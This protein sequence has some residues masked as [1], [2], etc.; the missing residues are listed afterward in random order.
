MLA[1][2][3]ATG[4]SAAALREIGNGHVRNKKWADAFV[5][6]SH[7]LGVA[8]QRPES[9][10]EGLEAAKAATNRAFVNLQ[11]AKE[12]V[13]TDEAA[14]AIERNA[15]V[16]QQVADA[17]ARGTGGIGEGPTPRPDLMAVLGGATLAEAAAEGRLERWR[18][19]AALAFVDAYRHDG[20]APGWAT[21]MARQAEAARFLATQ[22]AREGDFHG[23]NVMGDLSF[24]LFKMAADLEEEPAAK[25]QY[26]LLHQHMKYGC[27]R[28]LVDSVGETQVTRTVLASLEDNFGTTTRQLQRAGFRMPPPRVGEEDRLALFR[29]SLHATILST[30]ALQNKYLRDPI[31]QPTRSHRARRGSGGAWPA[32]APAS[33]RTGSTGG[34]SLWLIRPN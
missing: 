34:S 26:E 20:L 7:A 23:L 28:T 18:M 9:A 15:G 8:H 1:E 16:M 2:A 22:C 17:K 3:K 32:P 13:A 21:P 4:L 6:Y 25:K 10:D 11:L 30:P 31:F 14:M 12:L 33:L 19:H 29:G 5:A 27:V 24:G